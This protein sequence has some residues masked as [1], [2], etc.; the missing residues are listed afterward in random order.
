MNHKHDGDRVLSFLHAR[1]D[2]SV[3]RLCALLWILK[4][5]EDDYQKQKLVLKQRN[6]LN[7]AKDKGNADVDNKTIADADTVVP[8]LTDKVNS[9]HLSRFWF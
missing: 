8:Q 5:Q 6:E 2:R 3:L 4:V 7:A 1:S 9:I